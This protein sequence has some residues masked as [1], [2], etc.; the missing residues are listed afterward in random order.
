MD[1]IHIKSDISYKGGRI[2]ASNLTPEDP[3]KTVFE[4][5]VSSLHKKWSCIVPNYLILHYRSRKLWFTSASYLNRQLPFKREYFK[6]FLM[7]TED[8]S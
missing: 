2:F 3:T 1:E 7:K 8:F 4:I 5:M 6:T